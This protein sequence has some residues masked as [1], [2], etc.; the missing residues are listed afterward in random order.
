MSEAARIRCLLVEDDEDDYLLLNDLL[1]DS[2]LFSLDLT[3]VRSFDEARSQLDAEMYDIGLVDYRIGAET[4]LAFIRAAVAGGCQVPLILLTGLANREIDIEASEAGAADFLEKGR[5]SAEILERTIRYAIVQARNRADLAE[6]TALLTATLEH[7]GAGIAA[8]DRGMQLVACNSRLRDLLQLE[9]SEAGDGDR[10]AVSAADDQSVGDALL[11]VVDIDLLQSEGAQEIT[12]P[13]ARIL[14]VRHNAAPQG[15]HVL[16]CLDITERKAAEAELVRSKEAAD[17]ANRAKS[18]FLANVSHEL[19]TPL[20]A[21]IGFSEIMMQELHGPL[22]DEKYRVYIDDV[23]HSGEH[24]LGIINNIL[25]LSKIE[26]GITEIHE[27][28]VDLGLL[29]SFCLRQTAPQADEKGVRVE[30]RI[31]PDLRAVLGDER[32]LRQALINLLSNAVKFTPANGM[33]ALKI[34]RTDDRRLGFTVRDTGIG[35]AAA[36]IEKCLTPFGQADSE[37]SRHYEGTGLGLPLVKWY[38]ELHGGSFELESEPGIGTTARI[39]L[40][41]TRIA[42]SAAVVVG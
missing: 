8:F 32:A 24:L 40:P 14:E 3:W 6:R 39:L 12:T 21:I 27:V 30:S 33:V 11:H 26:A 19:R 18:A 16:I 22:G 25:D 37:L 9:R 17:S 4:G 23:Y 31:A 28:A 20:N 36:D 15:M 34:G 1:S 35:I 7:T 10:G 38:A 41:E 42:A 5:L 2:K 29:V 13:Q